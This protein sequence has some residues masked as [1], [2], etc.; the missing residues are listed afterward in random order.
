MKKLTV[1]RLLALGLTL[2]MVLSM[3]ACGGS[4]D[5]SAETTSDAAETTE[6]SDDSEAAASGD[7][8]IAYIPKERAESFW[9]AVEAGAQKAAE[10]LGCELI[11]YG[12]AAGANT[13]WLKAADAALRI[14]ESLVNSLVDHTS[15]PIDLYRWR[16]Q[17][18]E[19][20]ER[21]AE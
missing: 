16:N 15:D 2:A 3:A 20:I 5:D 6:T 19:L 7:V 18:A 14:P 11:M 10:D 4:G 1:K 8:T 13:A 21:K 9:Q 12:D 17:L